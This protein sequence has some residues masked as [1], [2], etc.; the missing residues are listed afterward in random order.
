MR[1]RESA[2]APR[3]GVKKTGFATKKCASLTF[4]H[5][6]LALLQG[7]PLKIITPGRKIPGVLFKHVV[8]GRGN[9]TVRDFFCFGLK[10]VLLLHSHALNGAWA[11]M[12]MSTC[13]T[14]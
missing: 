3:H 1:H 12:A 4:H 13:Y 6:F 5:L 11:V 7:T 8:A 10:P 2:V 14:R 9:E